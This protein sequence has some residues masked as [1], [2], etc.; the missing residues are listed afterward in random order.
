[1]TTATAQP[2]RSYLPPAHFRG[3]ELIPQLVS[4]RTWALYRPLEVVVPHALV[5]YFPDGSLRHTADGWVLAV[6]VGFETD[7]ASIPRGFRW[8]TVRDA[9]TA[10]AAT[11][12]DYLYREVHPPREIADRMMRYIMVVTDTHKVRRILIYR[13]V[14][15]GGWAAYRE[16]EGRAITNRESG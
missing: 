14:R 7:F 9:E 4:K 10:A 15:L 11:V 1:M 3:T 5:P 6:P 8:L 2:L 16:H 12:H 13:G